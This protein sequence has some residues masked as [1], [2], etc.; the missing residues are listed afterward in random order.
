MQRMHWSYEELMILPVD[1]YDQLIEMFDED[2]RR[3]TAANERAR[4]RASSRR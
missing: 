2:D 3:Q 4:M 1:Y